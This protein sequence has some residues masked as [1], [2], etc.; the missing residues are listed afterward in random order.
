MEKKR[1]DRETLEMGTSDS[2]ALGAWRAIA[3]RQYEDRRK[4]EALK[5]K[6]LVAV[7]QRVRSI[8][9]LEHVV[10]KRVRVMQNLASLEELDLLEKKPRVEDKDTLLF[11]TYF[12]DLDALYGKVDEVFATVGLKP[13]PGGIL[14]GQH[15]RAC[16]AVWGLVSVPHR[17]EGRQ[18][19]HGLPD[20]DNLIALQCTF[21]FGKEWKS[22]HG[23]IV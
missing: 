22:S 10:R 12:Q 6:L 3:M 19:Y 5:K 21:D 13:A 23:T 8:Q 18:V 7:T 16:D 17:Q 11:T 4:A 2:L 9:D 20:S 14:S 15:T 1:K